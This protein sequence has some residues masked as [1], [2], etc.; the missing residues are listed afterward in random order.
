MF[1]TKTSAMNQAPW[2]FALVF[3]LLFAQFSGLQHRIEHAKWNNGQSIV[4]ADVSH[5][6][7]DDPKHSCSLFDAATLADSV[8]AAPP[9]PLPSAGAYLPALWL[10]R[11]SWDAPL[12]L[13][14]RS[15]APPGHLVLK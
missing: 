9:C 8:N 12:L 4:R 5:N 1:R 3:S 13:P 14:F 7:K 2:L 11:A 15:R 6:A 10:M